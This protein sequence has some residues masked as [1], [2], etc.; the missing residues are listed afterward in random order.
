MLQF[1]LNG[2]RRFGLQYAEESVEASVQSGAIGCIAHI[3]SSDMLPDGRSNIRVTGERRYEVVRLIP[4]KEPFLMA[5]VRSYDDVDMPGAGAAMI[6]ARVRPLFD[7]VARAARKLSSTEQALPPLPDDPG[8]LSFAI[9][10]MLDLDSEI[11]QELL[12]MRSLAGRLEEIERIL[13]AAVPPMEER[14][15]VHTRAKSN[16]TGLATH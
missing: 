14:A 9:P 13:A 4:V 2:D 5:E 15:L 6:A 10:S 16:G 8:A 7:R 3:E 11:R 1:C 12:A